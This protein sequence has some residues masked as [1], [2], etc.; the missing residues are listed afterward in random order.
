MCLGG[1]SVLTQIC[2]CVGNGSVP[3][4]G[5]QLALLICEQSDQIVNDKSVQSGGCCTFSYVPRHEAA[6]RTS[7]V[8]PTNVTVRFVSRRTQRASHRRLVRTVTSEAV[9]TLLNLSLCV[10][11]HGQNK[12]PQTGSWVTYVRFQMAGCHFLFI[13]PVREFLT[14]QT[15][16]YQPC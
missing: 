15:K 6:Q 8:T 7:A 5:R 4:S 3:A 11:P 1:D 10:V 16:Y 14:H 13:L 2:V 9:V 12:D